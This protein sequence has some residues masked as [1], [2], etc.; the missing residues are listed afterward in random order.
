MEKDV[1]EKKGRGMEEED[2][3]NKQ[4][5]GKVGDEEKEE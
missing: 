3:E 5:E 4:E 1:K 2:E